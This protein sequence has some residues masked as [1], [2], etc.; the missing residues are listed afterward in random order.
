MKN[1]LGTILIATATIILAGVAVFTAIRLF[2][3]RQQSVSPTEPES[4]PGAVYSTGEVRI[5]CNPNT[6]SKKFDMVITQVSESPKCNITKNVCPTTNNNFASYS[7]TYKV[8]VDPGNRNDMST[9]GVTVMKNSNWCSEPCGQANLDGSCSSN[10]ERIPE[11]FFLTKTNKS[12]NITVTRKSDNGIA[13]G[14]WQTDIWFTDIQDCTNPNPANYSIP[15]SNIGWGLCYTGIEC[16]SRP[17]LCQSLTVDKTEVKPG[18]SVTFTSVS[19]SPVK[20]FSYALYNE[21]NQYPYVEGNP[22]DNPKPIC[23]TNN[24]PPPE[25]VASILTETAGCQELGAGGS[26]HLIFSSPNTTSR[27][28]ASITVPYEYLFIQDELTKNQVKTIHINAY[29]RAEDGGLISIPEGP[30]VLN[31]KAVAG[32]TATATA[33]PVNN[34]SC[35]TVNFTLA[36][37]TATPTVTATATATS[38]ATPTVTATATATAT[39]TGAP[40]NCGGTC[41]S[42][43]NCEG[44]LYCY[45]GFCRNPS[46]PTE[47]DC[48]CTT[49]TP[50]PT[51]TSTTKVATTT[52]LPSAEPSLPSAGVSTPTLFGVGIGVILLLIS[53]ALA[54]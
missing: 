31:I 30:C 13:C 17:S 44:G 43:S 8:A 4:E 2:Q 10:T 1:K 14:S 21:D 39:S 25:G 54:L 40:N 35:P 6:P 20:Y 53:L 46:C 51:A 26:H 34:I 52:T 45:Q 33:V 24:Q 5:T 22:T 48:V 15:I 47:T 18:E 16:P 29:F 23:T 3:L 27:T 9:F 7:T 11:S 50:T 38:T 19:K 37:S 42:N 49:A 36:S 12:R 28:T 32:P 41:G